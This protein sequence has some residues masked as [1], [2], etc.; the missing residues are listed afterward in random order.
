M[1]GRLGEVDDGTS[2][3]LVTF[4]VHDPGQFFLTADR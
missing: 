1:L 2:P 3:G 4:Q